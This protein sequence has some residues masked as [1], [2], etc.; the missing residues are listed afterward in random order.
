MQDDVDLFR[1]KFCLSLSNHFHGGTNNS[2]VDDFLTSKNSVDLL[3]RE[4]HLK[5]VYRKMYRKVREGNQRLFFKLRQVQAFVLDRRFFLESHS[6]LFG[7]NQK[8]C[9]LRS[10][11]FIV[12]EAITKVSYESALNSDPMRT[13]DV[14]RNHL[15]E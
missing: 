10:G 14:H 7:E 9:G 13:Q 6:I 5:N 4:T 15:L 2:C 12:T 3:N 11:R 8:L 1:A